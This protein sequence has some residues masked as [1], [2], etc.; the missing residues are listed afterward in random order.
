[1]Q[2]IVVKVVHLPVKNIK[3]YVHL[4]NYEYYGK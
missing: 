3:T 4:S 2:E 1:L